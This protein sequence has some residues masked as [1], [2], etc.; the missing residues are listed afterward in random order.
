MTDWLN[1]FYDWLIDRM[2]GYSIKWLIFLM[3]DLMTE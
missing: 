2:A 1:D 3:K